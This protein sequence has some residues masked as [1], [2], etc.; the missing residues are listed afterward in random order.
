MVPRQVLWLRPIVL[1][2]A[3]SVNL[4]RVEFHLALLYKK[5]LGLGLE[6]RFGIRHDN[7]DGKFPHPP[8]TSDLSTGRSW[9][10]ECGPQIEPPSG[11]LW[12]NS[13]ADFRFQ[14]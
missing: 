4:F 2:Q 10:S 7:H 8:E 14:S 9:K 13:G 6:L 3:V 11:Y 1:K 12:L 5:I